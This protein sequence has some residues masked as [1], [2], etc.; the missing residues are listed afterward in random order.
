MVNKKANYI[1]L[2]KH[3]NPVGYQKIESCVEKVMLELN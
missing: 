1:K 2:L 3:P